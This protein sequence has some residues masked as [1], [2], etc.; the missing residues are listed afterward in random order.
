M[1]FLLRFEQYS[2]NVNGYLYNIVVVVK[3]Q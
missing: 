2:V 1:I 3:F